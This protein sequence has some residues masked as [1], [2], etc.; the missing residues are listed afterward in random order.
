MVFFIS[1][2]RLPSF[3]KRSGQL[4]GSGRARR[5]AKAHQPA[6]LHAVYNTN[7][8]AAARPRGSTAGTGGPTDLG[9][10]GCGALRR[11]SCVVLADGGVLASCSVFDSIAVYFIA[12]FKL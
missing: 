4:S 3:D 9:G 5:D 6:S 12:S 10:L 2:E 11:V 7:R 8:P 1:P